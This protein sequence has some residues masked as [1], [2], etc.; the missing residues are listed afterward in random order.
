MGNRGQELKHQGARP[1]PFS[2]RTVRTSRLW[3]VPGSKT[4]CTNE[5][6][7]NI[8]PIGTERERSVEIIA[9][10]TRQIRTKIRRLVDMNINKSTNCSQRVIAD[11]FNPGTP[12]ELEERESPPQLLMKTYSILT[13]KLKSGHHLWQTQVMSS[14]FRTM[15]FRDHNSKSL[16]GGSNFVTLLG[17]PVWGI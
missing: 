11:F 6:E 3:P 8:I 15:S 9:I 13:S 12:Q 7:S 4:A 1:P 10:Q 17:K 2:S 14:T 16:T 5:P